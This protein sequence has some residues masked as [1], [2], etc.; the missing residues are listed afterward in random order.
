MNRR[1]IFISHPHVLIDPATPVPRWPLSPKG[2]ERMRAGM[3]QPWVGKI[4]AIH[5][6]TEAKAMGGAALPAEN[7]NLPLG[8]HEDLGE[9]DRSST[10]FVAP[11]EFEPM[12]DAFF[13]N[14]EASVCRW[15]RAVDAQRRIVG[16]VEQLSSL[17]N[18]DGVVASVSHGAVG[19]LLHCRLAG[20]AISRRWDQPA[21]GGGNFY[22]FSLSPRG[23]ESDWRPIDGEL[24]P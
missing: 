15:E 11:Q 12:A 14:A 22:G 17:D 13:A 10:D 8:R 5:S 9:N 6:S 19:T 7:L 1:W 2:R 3:A 4:S 23:M 20:R 16:V 18:G 24:I 21:N